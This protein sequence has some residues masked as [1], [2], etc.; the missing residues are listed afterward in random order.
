MLMLNRLLTIIGLSSATDLNKSMVSDEIVLPFFA[1]W[2]FL[3][4]DF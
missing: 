4:N 3:V 1:V 2:V